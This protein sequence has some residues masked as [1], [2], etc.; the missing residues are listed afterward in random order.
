MGRMLTMLLA[1]GV[2]G[3]LGY[4][5]INGDFHPAKNEAAGEFGK[6]TPQVRMEAARGAAA[7]IEQQGQQRVDDVEAKQKEFEKQ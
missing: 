2:T 5:Y 3:Y 7:R 6:G 4:K 1:L